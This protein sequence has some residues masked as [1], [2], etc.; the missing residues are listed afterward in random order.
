MNLDST[1]AQSEIA[2]KSSPRLVAVIDIGA[3]SLRMQ[4]AEISGEGQVRK[5]ESFSQAV[6]LGKDSFANGKIEKGTIEDCV[7]VLDIYR[8]KLDE[9]GIP[10]TEQTRVI[11]TSGVKDASNRMAFL[12]RIFIA[13]GFDIELIDDAELHRITFLGVL[14][15]ITRHP[16]VFSGDSVVCEVGGGTTEVLALDRKDVMYSQTMR[17]G[18]LRLRI[19]LDSMDVPV[20][21][22][23]ELIQAQILQSIGGLPEGIRKSK[24]EA[25][26]ALG[27]DIRFAA[28]EIKGEALGD[29]LVKIKVKHLEKFVEGVNEMKPDAIATKYHFSLPDAESLGPGLMAHLMMAK[30]LKA[31]HFYVLNVSVRDGLVQEMARGW[32]WSDSIQRQIVRSA[33]QVGKKYG[34]DKNHAN[35]VAHLACQLFD[36]LR[37]IHYMNQRMRGILEIAA[38]VHEVG[39][40]ISLRSYHKHTMYLV[41]N[42]EFF[43]IGSSDV[44]LVALVARYHRRATPQPQHDAYSSL[45]RSGRVVV[46]KLA[47]ILRV[48]KA[49]DASRNQRIKDAKVRIEGKQVVVEVETS[50]DLSLEQLEL[51]RVSKF[52]EAIFGCRIVMEKPSD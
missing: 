11:A 44:K 46:S 3:T 6:S 7:H 45:K 49:L 16:D 41:R 37:S 29:D 5:I 48:A 20:G 12:D 42:S 26:I 35:Q 43:G 28:S 25:Y 51:S 33:K 19:A 1:F 31:Q 23:Q 8:R 39:K 27:S 30:E 22:T 38:L 4:I 2:E 52:F 47:A 15:S 10:A 34:V 14:P 9:Y 21:R 40:Y 36:Q 17:L 13:T 32:S 18:A 24:I 50:S